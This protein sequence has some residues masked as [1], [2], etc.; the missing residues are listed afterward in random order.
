L[1]QQA[2]RRKAPLREKAV[3]RNASLRK[4]PAAHA[5]LQKLA[6]ERR[7]ESNLRGEQHPRARIELAGCRSLRV[8]DPIADGTAIEPA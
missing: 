3:V 8:Q 2:L 7:V 1:V 6:P 5:P 4:R